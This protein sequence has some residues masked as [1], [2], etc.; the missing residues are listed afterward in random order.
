MGQGSPTDQVGVSP[1]P[2][3]SAN[4]MDTSM[5]PSPSSPTEDIIEKVAKHRGAMSD[6]MKVELL[7]H[8]TEMRRQQQVLQ[9]RL[10]ALEKEA[11]TNKESANSMRSHFVDT[12]MPF[13][14]NMLGKRCV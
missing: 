9:E 5:D 3:R 11:N 4:E 8:N 10:A 1:T 13:L 7:E 14:K 2:K 12:L 6:T